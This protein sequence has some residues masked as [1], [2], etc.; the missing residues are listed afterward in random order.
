MNEWIRKEKRKQ[1]MK[2]RQE[3]YSLCSPQ[4]SCVVKLFKSDG[5]DLERTQTYLWIYARNYNTDF[6]NL[7]WHVSIWNNT[8]EKVLV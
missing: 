2:K 7:L 8:I 6:T 3:M 5:Y 4:T 1:R